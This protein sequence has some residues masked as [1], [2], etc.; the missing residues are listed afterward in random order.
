M[1]YIYTKPWYEHEA[2]KL[3]SQ[4]CGLYSLYWKKLQS[5]R[6]SQIQDETQFKKRKSTYFHN[7]FGKVFFILNC[8]RKIPPTAFILHFSRGYLHNFFLRQPSPVFN[9]VL[10]FTNFTTFHPKFFSSPLK[11][12]FT[13]ACMYVVIS[14]F[15]SPSAWL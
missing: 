2:R 9:K 13:E 3:Y 14:N 10:Y 1:I 12:K 15:L 8:W 7:T 11:Y 6:F 4:I 5:L